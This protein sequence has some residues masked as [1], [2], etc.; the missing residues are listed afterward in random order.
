MITLSCCM[1]VWCDHIIANGPTGDDCH[2]APICHL[3]K[4]PCFSPEKCGKVTFVF[5]PLDCFTTI[6]LSMLIICQSCPE[7]IHWST[8]HRPEVN[9]NSAAP[10]TYQVLRNFDQLSA[11]ATGRQRAQRVLNW[12]MARRKEQMMSNIRKHSIKASRWSIATRKSGPW[13]R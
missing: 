8:I 12:L 4:S 2:T 6:A 5:I 1:P 11:T 10:S 7:R 3:Q 9:T 13:L